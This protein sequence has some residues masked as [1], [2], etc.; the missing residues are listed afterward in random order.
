MKAL[1]S[2]FLL[3]AFTLLSVGCSGSKDKPRDP[4][5]KSL[6]EAPKA[7]SPPQIKKKGD[8]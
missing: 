1:V 4:Q 8:Q 7:L 3:A 2:G 5:E 6:P